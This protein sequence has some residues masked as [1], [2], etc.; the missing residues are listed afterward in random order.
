M[1]NC[2]LARDFL[3]MH[4]WLLSYDPQNYLLKNF[5]RSGYRCLDSFSS[6]VELG[7]TGLN[8]ILSFL[9]GMQLSLLYDI[10]M[11]S[12][13]AKIFLAN[14]WALMAKST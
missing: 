2:L 7:V 14:S 12:S 1:R 10:R 4:P 8:S 13:L 9:P 6:L 3:P 11:Q 5:F